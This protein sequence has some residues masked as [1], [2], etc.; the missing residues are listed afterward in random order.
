MEVEFVRESLDYT[1]DK[2][3][4]RNYVFG[5]CDLFGNFSDFGV[6]YDFFKKI[7]NFQNLKK[8]PDRANE[9]V[10]HFCRFRD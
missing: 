3:F 10:P 2:V 4:L 9:E 1:V 6:F 5:I 7:Q 8:L